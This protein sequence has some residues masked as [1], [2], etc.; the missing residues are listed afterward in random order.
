MEQKKNITLLWR[1]L[2]SLEFGK[3]VV[4]VPYYWGKL[5]I[6]SRNLLWLFRR[7]CNT[8]FQKTEK[9]FALCKKTIR[10]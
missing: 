7:N 2:N 1:K 8:N 5:R 6:P 10:I 4:L 3:D 9:G